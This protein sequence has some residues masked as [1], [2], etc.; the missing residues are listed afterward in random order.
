MDDSAS[1]VHAWAEPVL[2]MEE[3]F[4]LAVAQLGRDVQSVRP[5]GDTLRLGLVP[6]GVA[7]LVGDATAMT[8]RRLPTL[9]GFFRFV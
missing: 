6:D 7:I 5:V 2:A 8:V 4:V 3:R 1:M 9:S